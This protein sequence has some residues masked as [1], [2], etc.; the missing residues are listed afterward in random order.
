MRL[1][2][3]I[4][5][6]LA[7]PYQFESFVRVMPAAHKS[8]P[9]GTGYG[10]SRFSST[11]QAFRLL[12]AAPDLKTAL[13]ETLIRDRF[14]GKAKRVLDMTEIE[15]RVV[16]EISTSSPLKLLDLRK[17]G[18]L[19]LG[20]STDAARA[21][22]IV[23]EVD[24]VMEGRDVRTPVADAVTDDLRARY[25]DMPSH[26]ARGLGATYAAVVEIRDTEAIN[27]VRRETEMRDGLGSGTRDALL[28]ARG[29]TAPQSARTDRLA[30]EIARVLDH[31]RA[32]EFS[33]PFETEAERDAFRDEIARVLDVRQLDRL[34]SGDADALD[35]VFSEGLARRALCRQGLPAIRC[36]DG[37]YGGLAP[38][39][40]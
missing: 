31:E 15:E 4:V 27:Q 40:R 5:A 25:P 26:L 37:Q 24:R 10:T 3:T 35:K 33:A 39:G 16:A 23:R 17:D 6:E 11:R 20:V 1:A 38:G 32:G 30:D 12:Y 19:K 34:T 2:P 13:A 9:L 8:T 29:E 21:S 22:E 7:V 28:A 14:E 36:S 18:L